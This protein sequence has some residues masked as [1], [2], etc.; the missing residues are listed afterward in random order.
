MKIPKELKL[1][2][3]SFPTAN[4]IARELLHQTTAMHETK[5]SAPMQVV[6]KL[7][8]MFL[9]AVINIA[10]SAWRIRCK[11]TDSSGEPLEEISKA[12]TKKIPKYI[13]SIF[14][15]LVS[16]GI[17][18]KDRTGEVF[19]YGLP[20]KVVTT[21]PQPGINKERIVETLSPT[22]Y[23]RSQIAQLGE[24]VIATPEKSTNAHAALSPAS[25]SPE[26]HLKEGNATQPRANATVQKNEPPES[27]SIETKIEINQ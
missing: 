23:W 19:D 12:D 27:N 4:D 15:S 13:E 7:P 17:E 9:K 1:L 22:I 6:E 8:D 25:I 3:A 20:E 16:L 21:I 5:V 11:V 24:V 18:V 2:P 10:T 26:S 14:E